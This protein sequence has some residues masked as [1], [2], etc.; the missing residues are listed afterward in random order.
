MLE[1]VKIEI[2]GTDHNSD[3]GLLLVDLLVQKLQKSKKLGQ[4]ER[5]YLD[6]VIKSQGGK[7]T[8]AQM[9]KDAGTNG[10]QQLKLE[11]IRDREI[12]DAVPE[13]VEDELEVEAY[14]TDWEVVKAK[15]NWSDTFSKRR[16]M[17]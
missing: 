4:K 8:L 1:Y 3:E 5:H 17:D 6:A 11:E 16:K 7:K 13:A 15:L 2:G 10:L 9:V 14:D 12:L